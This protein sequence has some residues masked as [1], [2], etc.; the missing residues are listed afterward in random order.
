MQRL[1]ISAGTSRSRSGDVSRRLVQ[2]M[3]GLS[4]HPKGEP[5][6]GLE[7]LDALAS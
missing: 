7:V 5:A 6:A 4:S 1:G 3:G 2:V